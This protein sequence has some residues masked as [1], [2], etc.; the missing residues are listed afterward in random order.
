MSGKVGTTFPSDI[1]SNQED[2]S[3][4]RFQLNWIVLYAE[5]ILS[6]IAWRSDSTPR[7]ASN[8]VQPIGPMS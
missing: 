8:L 4:I 2:E 3:T 5:R 7:D 1:A 6:R